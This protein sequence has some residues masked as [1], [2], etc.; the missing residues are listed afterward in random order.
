[1]AGK[2][3]RFYNLTGGLNTVQDLA[4]LNSGTNRTESPDMK[5]IEYYKYGGIQTM[6]GNKLIGIPNPDSSEDTK[7]INFGIEYIRGNETTMLVA[8]GNSGI[9]EYDG[10][11]NFTNIFDIQGLTITRG[12]DYFFEDYTSGTPPDIG[13]NRYMASNGGLRKHLAVSYDNGIV[14]TNGYSLLYYN[15]DTNSIV[16]YIPLFKIMKTREK[17]VTYYAWVNGASNTE[18]TYLTKVTTGA[19]VDVYAADY[20]KQSTKG[21]ITTKEDGTTILTWGGREYT[22]TASADPDIRTEYEPYYE[23]IPI[24][25]NAIASYKGRLWLACNELPRTAIKAIFEVNEDGETTSTTY[26]KLTDEDYEL[27]KNVLVYSGVGL[28]ITTDTWTEGVEEDDAGYFANFFEDYSSFTALM[29]WTEYLAVHKLQNTYL[30][31]GTSPDSS[32]WELKPYSDNSTDGQQGIVIANNSYYTYCRKSGG[33][34]PLVQRS[35]YNTTFQGAELSAKIKDSLEYVDLTKLDCI[36]AAY[37]PL[38]GYVMF[39]MPTLINGKSNHC[40]IYDI[41]S[42]T[43]LYREIPQNPTCV[44]RFD[45]DIYIGTEDGEVLKEFSGK[46]FN[47]KP[48]DFYWLSP[49]YLWGGGTNKTTTSEFRVKLLQNNTNNFYIESLRDGNTIPG[50]R[51]NITNRQ[52]A[53]N[54][55]VWDVGFAPVD[56]RK[57]GKYTRYYNLGDRNP[58]NFVYNS[59]YDFWTQKERQATWYKYST[60]KFGDVVTPMKIEDYSYNVPVYKYIPPKDDDN[61]PGDFGKLLGYNQDIDFYTIR[62]LQ[63]GE[64]SNY[65]T[66]TSTKSY[67]WQYRAISKICFRSATTGVMAWVPVSGGQAETNLKTKEVVKWIYIQPW[68][69]TVWRMSQSYYDL[70]NESLHKHPYT[71]YSSDYDGTGVEKWAKTGDLEFKVEGKMSDYGIQYDYAGFNIKLKLYINMPYG[72]YIDDGLNVYSYLYKNG[73]LSF[74]QRGE[75]NKYKGY[76]DLPISK[77]ETKT[78]EYPE[79]TQPIP[80]I[81]KTYTPTS[82]TED[83]TKIQIDYNGNPITLSRYPSGDFIDTVT[84]NLLYTQIDNPTTS[85]L[86]YTNKDFTD[87]GKAITAKYNKYIVVENKKYYRS[88]VNDSTYLKATPAYRESILING[89]EQLINLPSFDYDKVEA[90]YENLKSVTDTAW[91][92]TETDLPYIIQRPT[93]IDTVRYNQTKGIIYEDVSTK[94]D[95]GKYSDIPINLRGEA[96]LDQGYVTKRMILPKQYY[97]TVQFRFSGDTLNDSICL[98]GF[99]I[100]GIEIT[101][102]PH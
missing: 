80:G 17:K 38:K 87:T 90:G 8:D 37:H 2:T 56:K 76:K 42:K 75:M 36:Y 20:Q 59:V 77:K 33:I 47:G 57:E 65:T 58:I 102:V 96:W 68:A 10:K 62:D 78:Q 82:V 51:R 73:N 9:Y 94:V 66:Y 92:Y 24:V 50:K 46:T 3:L 35:V 45:N 28:G 64:T 44:F 81:T 13:A 7:E 91:D 53:L 55:L 12:K 101:E 34:Y 83:T 21:N 22:R 41:K 60:G 93:D 5:N 18:A 69:Q 84:D 72:K 86:A 32:R 29:P 1:M 71:Y 63:P 48:I 25:A 85:D 79:G 40:F 67:A 6:K 88:S 49:S 99:E 31:D 54:G 89:T 27:Y 98:A 30:L 100:D 39:Y 61:S 4:T 97:E 19:S 70:Y 14:F 43:W 16:N 15:K 11:G 74:A 26:Q 95:T 52:D 23:G